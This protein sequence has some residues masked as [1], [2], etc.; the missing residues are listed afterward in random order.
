MALSCVRL[1]YSAQLVDLIALLR[2]Y[3]SSAGGL[4]W[5]ACNG[6]A[7]SVPQVSFGDFIAAVHFSG[8]ISQ[9]VH[10]IQHLLKA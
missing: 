7:L 3:A 1:V 6:T 8:A 4:L 5:H 10:E 2:G 9:C